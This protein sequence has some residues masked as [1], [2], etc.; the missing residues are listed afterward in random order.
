MNDDIKNYLAK[1]AAELGLERADQL[2]E[3]QAHLETLHPQTYRAVT[4]NN[5]VLNIKTASA[6]AASDLRHAQ[7]EL[8]TKFDY[9]KRL[10]I[11][12]G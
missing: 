2:A 8:L 10:S 9:I 1:K 12:I 4:I 5:G 11:K 6:S 7:V 3:I